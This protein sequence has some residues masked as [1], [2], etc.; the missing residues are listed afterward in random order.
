M[1]RGLTG[2]VTEAPDLIMEEGGS[3]AAASAE[4]PRKKLREAEE[5]L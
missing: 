1:V 5:L 3:S 4:P 2:S